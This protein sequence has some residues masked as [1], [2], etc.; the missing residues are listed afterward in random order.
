MTEKWQRK[1]REIVL[2]SPWIKVYKD[3]YVLS[4][5]HEVSDYFI[6]ESGDSA[7]CVCKVGEDNVLLTRQYRPGIEKF[8]LCHPGGRLES[9]DASPVSGAMRELLEET[10]YSPQKVTSLG[11]FGQIPAITPN[12]IHFFLVECQSSPTVPYLDKSEKIDVEFIPIANLGKM[13]A[14]GDMDCVACVAAT[15]LAL[16]AIKK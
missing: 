9:S 14:S 11:M 3:E 2:E 16:D 8:T 6:W 7:L 10:G 4:S 12:K 15:Y 13:I 5:G 1:A